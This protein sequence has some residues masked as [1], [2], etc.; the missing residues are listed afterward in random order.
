[1]TEARSDKARWMTEVCQR[2]ERGTA[3]EFTAA[4]LAQQIGEVN[5]LGLTAFL[6]EM[7]D[8]ELATRRD[9][10]L[11]PVQGCY[12]P[13]PLGSS[14]LECPYCRSDYREEGLHPTPEAYYRLTGELCR[15]LRW[16]IVIHGMNSRAP[17]Q[18]AFSWEIASR[19]KQSAPVLIYKYGWA[20]IEVLLPFAH[21]R[22]AKR[23]GARIRLAI[24]QAGS[25]GRNQRPDLIAHSFGTRLLSL[26]LED[27]TFADLKLGRIITAGS[28][29]PPN[30]DWARHLSDGRIEGVLNHVAG[31]DGSVP[32]AEWTTPGSG[33]GGKLGYTSSAALNVRNATYGHSD[34]FDSQNMAELIHKNGLWHNFLTRP[35]QYFSPA[36]TFVV[37]NAWQK[38]HWLVMLLPRLVLTSIFLLAL[39]FS[40][41]RRVVDP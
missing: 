4:Q 22:L 41:L 39:P 37:S 3:L 14:L 24:E 25:A 2:L 29:I 17:W 26:V 34:Y 5:T 6:D 7:V 35:L 38:K 27:P 28:I 19:L 16:M 18:E 20:T 1:M 13:L 30:F 40:A 15:D 8:S 33:P 32:F 31:K 21:R 23:L 10:F 9:T 12:R 36:E 11:C